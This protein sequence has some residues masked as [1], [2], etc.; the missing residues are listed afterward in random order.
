METKATHGFKMS[1]GEDRFNEKIP[2]LGGTV[3]CKVSAVDSREGLCVYDT[4][5]LKKGGPPHHFHYTQDEWFYILEGEFIFKVG[6]DIFNAKAG[7]AVFA[8]R[9]IPHSF[10]KLGDD[11]ARMLMVY[12]PAG[13]MDEFYQEASQL[14]EGTL[15]D[16]ERL[17]RI[18]GMEIVGPPLK[19]E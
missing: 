4:T 14:P 12:Q 7:D 13:T 9:Q 6:D 15:R 18:H 16:Y 8:P 2:F 5:Q 19:L 3:A 1:A 11:S 17:Y 10:T